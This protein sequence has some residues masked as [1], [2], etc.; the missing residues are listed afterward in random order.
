ME[1]IKT[2]TIVGNVINVYG[3]NDKPLFLAKDVA[4]WI[5]YNKNSR[6]YYDTN[7]MLRT[8]DDEDKISSP[9]NGRTTNFLTEYGVYEVLMQSRKPRAKQ[10]KKWVKEI[11]Q[12]IRK[13]GGY[14]KEDR[15]EEFID[16]YFTS[17]SDEVK[18]TMVLDLKKSIDRMKPKE[19][20][21]DTVTQSEDTIDIGEVAKVLNKGMG[22]NQLYNFLRDKKVLMA[23]NEPYQRF[24]KNGCFKRVE[25]EY[26][27]EKTG[28][29]G[30]GLKTVVFQKGVD[31]INKLID[32]EQ[33][34][35]NERTIL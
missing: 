2:E 34:N 26:Y 12:D 7:A 15:E 27:N 9:I 35:E 28:K 29:T 5:E 10:F 31:Y 20:F 22:R 25:Q 24:V 14:V 11:L 33:L 30:I 17:F 6:G 21:Y 8:V 16:K 19:L 18:K 1:L 23:D 3:T 32:K 4:E 13:T